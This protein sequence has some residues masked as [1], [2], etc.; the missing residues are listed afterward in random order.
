MSVGRKIRSRYK[1]FPTSYSVHQSAAVETSAARRPVRVVSLSVHLPPSRVVPSLPPAS[2]ADPRSFSPLRSAVSR[3]L[4]LA[5]SSA[6][7]KVVCLLTPLVVTPLWTRV[8]DF[9]W[10][11]PWGL[12]CGFCYHDCWRGCSHGCPCRSG[13]SDYFYDCLLDCEEIR[14]SFHHLKETRG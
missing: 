14:F 11:F 3:V 1:T 13:S 7:L 10:S 12:H 4:P 6:L 8:R 2:F 5:L 9:P